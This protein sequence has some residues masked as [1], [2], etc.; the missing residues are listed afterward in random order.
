VDE[1]CLAL[2]SKGKGKRKKKKG[3]K[4]NIEFSK[5]KFFQC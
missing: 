3:G 2:A 4:K 5:V 1:E